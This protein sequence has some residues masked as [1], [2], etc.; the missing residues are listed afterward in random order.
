MYLP[1]SCSNSIYVKSIF[2]S[3]HLQVGLALHK[4]QKN[5]HRLLPRG[6]APVVWEEGYPVSTHAR[7]IFVSV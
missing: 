7:W 1:W 6:E 5:C 4:W 3:S 2:L